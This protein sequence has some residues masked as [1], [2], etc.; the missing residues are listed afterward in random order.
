M[1][2]A[3]TAVFHSTSSSTECHVEIGDD[4]Q[5]KVTQAPPCSQ[6]RGWNLRESVWWLGITSL[7]ERIWTL[8]Q[9]GVSFGS[10]EQSED[11]VSRHLVVM[12]QLKGKP[13][14][15][16]SKDKKERKQAMQEARQQVATV[17]LPTLAV[18]V[19]LIIVF[20]Y[21]ATRPDTME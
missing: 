2:T 18:V 12:R 3:L 19:L 21:V 7:L 8:F 17:V 6:A 1:L 10:C 20:V 5:D 16:T 15:E 13:K 14:K 4:Q 9:C 11:R